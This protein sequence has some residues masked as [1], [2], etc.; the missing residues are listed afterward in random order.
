MSHRNDR[1]AD[2]QQRLQEADQHINSGHFRSA[3]ESAAGGVEL[4]L[5]GLFDEL[6]HSLNDVDFKLKLTLE[7][8]YKELRKQRKNNENL[9]FCDWID[10]FKNESIFDE[11]VAVHN[12]Q[13]WLFNPDTLHTVRFLRNRCV[14]ENYRPSIDE[15]CWV[16]NTVAVFLRETTRDA[17]EHEGKSPIVKDLT[18]DWRTTWVELID[19]WIEN[20]PDSQ[21][22]ELLS[23]LIDQEFMLIAG[24]ISDNRISFELKIK[25]IWAVLL[26]H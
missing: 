17:V 18:R 9:T 12:L 1:V 20:N 6:L 26:C 23:A 21:D 19:Q 4:M 16:R 15:A 14:H 2:C 10:F 13:L 7:A 5:Q 24:L 8:R 3:V 11:L 22:A 25:L